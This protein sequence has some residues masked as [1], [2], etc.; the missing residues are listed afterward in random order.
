MAPLKGLAYYDLDGTLVSS[1]VVHQYGFYA[2]HL[3]SRPQ[4]V[5]KTAKLVLSIPLLVALDLYSRRLF[6]R[7]FYGSYRGM[8]RQWLQ[9]SAD[10]LFEQVFR[11]AIYPGSKALIESD[12]AAG[13]RCVLVTGSLDFALG[14]VVRHFGFDDLISNRLVFRGG[15]ATGDIEPPLIAEREKVEAMERLCRRYN[16]N[17]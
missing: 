10:H 11:P 5:I 13:F 7:F 1:N 17:S 16:V 15:V 14:P 9:E 8:R 6:N 2:R 12:Q 3:P 4:A